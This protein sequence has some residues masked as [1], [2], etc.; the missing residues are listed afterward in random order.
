MSFELTVSFVN[1]KRIISY[2]Y[3]T[4]CLKNGNIILLDFWFL[5]KL[6]TLLINKVWED[7][8]NLWLI[9]RFS[10]IEKIFLHTLLDGLQ[11]KVD[12]R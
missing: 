2:F 1:F 9:S 11:N 6:L 4:H 8:E 12:V 5:K 7:E 10:R 3:H